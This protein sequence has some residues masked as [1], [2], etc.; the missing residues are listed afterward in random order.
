MRPE[1]ANTAQPDL[2]ALSSNDHEFAPAPPDLTALYRRHAAWLLRCAA[3]L[4]GDADE[5]ADLLQDLFLELLCTQAAYDPERGRERSW[6]Y[7]RLR[8]RA[9]DRRSSKRA[10][11]RTA[12]SHRAVIAMLRD[13]VDPPELAVDHQR[14]R[15]CLSQLP[16]RQREV[17]QLAYFSG[18]SH[19]AAAQTTA[20]SLG[21]IKSLVRN[22]LSRLRSDL[23]PAP[24]RTAG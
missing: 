7:L 18:L 12:R 11:R 19:S 24:Q 1:P 15:H 17:L 6:L 8:S 4:L 9:C 3:K 13:A 5:A 22:G 14:V 2:R 23:L 21:T 20:R 16:P 10:L